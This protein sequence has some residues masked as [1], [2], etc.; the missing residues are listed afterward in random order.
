MDGINFEVMADITD[1]QNRQFVINCNEMT[2]K[3][4]KFQ[5]IKRTATNGGYGIVEFEAYYNPE[6]VD[7]LIEA[8]VVTVKNWLAAML[9]ISS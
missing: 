2:V 8:K 1:G 4:V 9:V 5:G 6:I 3:F 7:Q